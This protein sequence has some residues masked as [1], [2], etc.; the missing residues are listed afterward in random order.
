MRKIKF[1]GK[2]RGFGDYAF[3]D[4]RHRGD[5]V[6][7]DGYRVYPESIAQLVGYDEQ[8]KE[9]YEGDE[10]A[11]PFNGK[12][13]TVKLQVQI[14]GENLSTQNF[15]DNFYSLKAIKAD[16][17]FSAPD[18][19]NEEFQKMFNEL[20]AVQGWFKFGN[21][22]MFEVFQARK[23]ISICGNFSKKS[24]RYLQQVLDEYGVESIVNRVGEESN[25]FS[26][27]TDITSENS[28]GVEWRNLNCL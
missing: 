20:L 17:L 11:D 1:R 27:L 28:I 3:G 7:V 24:F 18:L 13:G 16:V 23:N 6:F 21:T 26:K 12:T 22:P 19:S 5:E 15:I 14:S 10:V 25:R 8:G 2:M 9:I 4:L